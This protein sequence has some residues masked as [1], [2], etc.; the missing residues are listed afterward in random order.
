MK[1]SMWSKYST[2]DKKGIILYHQDYDKINPNSPQSKQFKT[3]EKSRKEKKN[4]KRAHWERCNNQ[5]D[6]YR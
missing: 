3:L 2:Q 4:K 1:D 6:L 5:H